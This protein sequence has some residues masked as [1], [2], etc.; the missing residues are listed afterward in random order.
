MADRDIIERGMSIAKDKVERSLDYMKQR[1][2]QAESPNR[3]SEEEQLHRYL[4]MT[5][6]ELNELRVR[7]GDKE[8]KRYVNTM[9]QYAR[10]I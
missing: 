10:R 8:F 5:P 3:I 7:F 2:P 6:E 1:L 4:S 9:R